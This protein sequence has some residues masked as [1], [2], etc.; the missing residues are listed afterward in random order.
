[1]QLFPIVITD[2]FDFRQEDFNDFSVILQ[3][4]GASFA[5]Q[6]PCE[7]FI[8]AFHGDIGQCIFLFQQYSC[9][10]WINGKGKACRKAQC[11]QDA[12]GIFFKALFRIA[13]TPDD[14]FFQI[15][16]ST[17]E[18]NKSLIWVVTHGID[19]KVSSLTVFFER[20][21]ELDMIGMP[22][23]LVG[24]I[25]AV[26][27]DFHRLVVNHDGNGTVLNAGFNQMEVM[28]DLLH[29]IRKGIC[30]DVIVM[31]NFSSETVTDSAADDI[32]L[33]SGIIE[34]FQ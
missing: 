29:L 33:K 16:F 1:M 6:D 27:R 34:L 17:E 31:G 20:T 23:V 2:G 3:N 28:K 7:F 13:N 26:C 10:I 19:R 4:V 8:D 11:P 5:F 32:G 21:G 22:V 12:Q 30:C 15:F 24:R 25:F 9:R 18:I 14:S